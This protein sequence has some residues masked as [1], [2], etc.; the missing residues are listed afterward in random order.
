MLPKSSHDHCLKVI[1]TIRCMI[2]KWLIR[3]LVMF[4]SPWHL[5]LP[6]NGL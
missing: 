2:P 6:S 1:T 4:Q 5:H 3:A